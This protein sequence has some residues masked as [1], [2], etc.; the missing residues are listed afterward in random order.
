DALTAAAADR[1]VLL[2]EV[3]FPS[4]SALGASEESQ[5]QALDA[6]FAALEPR[7]TRVPWILVHQL[8][9]LDEAAC[10]SLAAAQNEEPEGPWASYACHTGL[11][12][13][14]DEPKAA[15]GRFLEATARFASP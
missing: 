8:H 11:R 10:E 14:D 1:P 2:A 15:W 5:R 4:G 3:A 13:H 6:F 9:D 12:T 7:R